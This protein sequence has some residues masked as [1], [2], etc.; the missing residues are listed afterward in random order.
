MVTDMVS[1]LSK[2]QPNTPKP[3]HVNVTA[4]S[5]WYGPCLVSDL[6][7]SD[8]WIGE[9]LYTVNSLPVDHPSSY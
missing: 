8:C 4:A 6:F 2:T 1:P 7:V 9:S 3:S 5:L